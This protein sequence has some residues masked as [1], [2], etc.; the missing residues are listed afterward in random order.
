MN[1]NAEF[2][3]VL[4]GAEECIVAGLKYLNLSA[5]TRLIERSDQTVL[6]T[7]LFH[8]HC[9]LRP[10]HCIDSS[11]CIQYHHSHHYRYYLYVTF[12]AVQLSASYIHRT[13]SAMASSQTDRERETVGR[14][15]DTEYHADRRSYCMAKIIKLL[16]FG[17][18]H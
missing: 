5:C 13:L 1:L 6:L 14:T 7:E 18:K 17:N 15:E 2:S 12:T 10:N 11:N 3:H 9:C 8:R 16:H 4:D